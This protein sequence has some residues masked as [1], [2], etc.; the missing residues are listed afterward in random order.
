MIRAAKPEDISRIA[1][2]LVFS[3]RTNYRRIFHNDRVSFGEI[4]VYPIARNLIEHPE[5]LE[6]FWVYDDEFTKGFIHLEGT[7]IS[8]LYI[9]PFFEEKGIGS[10]LIE[11]AIQQKGCDHLWVLEKNEGAIRFYQRHGFSMTGERKFQE[12]TPEYIALMRR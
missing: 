11:F 4:Q 12:G 7:L 9:D 1:E 3:K 10:K 6:R 8:E 5:K 2:I